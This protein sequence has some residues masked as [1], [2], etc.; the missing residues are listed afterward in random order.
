MKHCAIS[1]PNIFSCF[2]FIAV[3]FLAAF[4]WLLTHHRRRRWSKNICST[5][6]LSYVSDFLGFISFQFNF[7]FSPF[8]VFTFFFLKIIIMLFLVVFCSR[9]WKKK[10]K[11]KKPKKLDEP[12]CKWLA[13]SNVEKWP[14]PS[15]SSKWNIIFHF[16]CRAAFALLLQSWQASSLFAVCVF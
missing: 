9:F 8:A 2:K 5:W 3:V 16:V 15:S 4:C 11:K 10:K 13:L 1:W 14:P 6:Q 7:F 12:T